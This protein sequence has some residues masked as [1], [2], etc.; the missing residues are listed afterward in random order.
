GGQLDYRPT[1]PAGRVAMPIAEMTGGAA[2]GGLTGGARGAVGNIVRQGVLPGA[3]VEG[4][5][6]AGV[7]NP[8]ALGAIALGTGGAAQMATTQSAAGALRGRA[9]GATEAQIQAAERL[10][11]LAQR[12]G[13][14]LS[15]AN[16]LDFVTS[17]GTNASG[18]QRVIENQSDPTMREF[19]AGSPERIQEAGGRA[20][21]TVGPVSEAPSTIGPRVAEQM[22]QRIQGTE[23]AINEYTRPAYQAFEREPLTSTEF[24]RLLQD[25]LFMRQH[26]RNF[27]DPELHHL[28]QGMQ[29]DSIEAVDLTRRLLRERQEALQ[30]PATE[31]YSPTRAGG[32]GAS[33]GTAEEV[34]N[35]ASRRA[36]MTGQGQPSPREAVQEAQARA[37]EALVDPLVQGP[38]GQIARNRTTGGAQEAVFPQ[39]PLE[40]AHVEVDRMVRALADQSPDLAREFVRNYLGTAF[41]KTQNRGQGGENYYHAPAFFAETMGNPEARA[42]VTAALRALPGGAARAEAFEDIMRVFQAMGKRERPGSMTAHAQEDIA[43]LKE[44]GLS[45]GAVK[46]LTSVGTAW[47]T[48]V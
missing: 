23:Q 14:P 2:V 11:Q 44:S 40:G 27:E 34:A 36:L 46:V 20:L 21:N 17:G 26:Q 33:T 9:A 42:S 18:L 7:E 6:A 3:A 28:T 47:P 4:A 35:E 22:D 19:Y 15:R 31:N 1:T 37:R 12:E 8:V 32:Y 13:V 41:A 45:E 16:A 39:K 29:P 25:P 10:Y 24:A 48:M 30:Q 5:K 43:A 38:E